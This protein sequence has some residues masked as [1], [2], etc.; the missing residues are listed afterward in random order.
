MTRRLRL[1]PF[2]LRDTLECGQFFR[3]TKVQD[4]Y[5]IQASDRIFSLWQTGDVLFY[6]GVEESFLVR[7]FRLEE[8][9]KRILGEI[10]QDPVIHQA[11]RRFPG[12]R[13][14]RQDPWEC[15]ISFLFSS[16]KAI[17]H[18]RC[19][20]E[21]LCKSSGKRA[22]WRT[23]LYYG[24]PTPDAI[25]ES[26]ALKEVR[27]GFRMSYLMEACHCMDRDRLLLLK[28]FPYDEAKKR[29]MELPGVGKKIADCVLLYSLDFLEAF[30]IDTWIKKGLQKTY[31]G[32]EKVSEMSME[33]FVR[34]HF[35]PSAGYAQLYLYHYW[36]SQSLLSRAPQ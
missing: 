1:A 13:L 17:P 23:H 25:E 29:L 31:F 5:L 28:R 9:L 21:A 14:I 19:L 35:G 15:L 30:P 26:R 10:D 36:R 33:E 27:A 16:A 22:A 8:D 4:T 12:L 11:I 3:F 20:I 24:F 2:S 7:F 18:I 6:E 34:D 32:G